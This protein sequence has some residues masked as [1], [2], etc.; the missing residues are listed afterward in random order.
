[1]VQ[2]PMRDQFKSRGVIPFRDAGRV[3]QKDFE[4]GKIILTEQK[5]AQELRRMKA[6][7]HQE[8]VRADIAEVGIETESNNFYRAEIERDISEI[9]V[10]KTLVERNIAGELLEQAEGQLAYLEEKT[11][12]LLEQWEE[13][14]RSISIKTDVRAFENDSLQEIAQARGIEI[15]QYQFKGIEIRGSLTGIMDGGE[16]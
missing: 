12:L 1:M 2:T 11:D 15:N 10:D 13:E 8:S 5:N 7:V 16:R 9:Q 14:L 4:I 3:R 6:D